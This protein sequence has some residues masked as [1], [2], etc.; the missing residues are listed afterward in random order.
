[1]LFGSGIVVKHIQ[2][3]ESLLV[4][5]NIM[6]DHGPFDYSAIGL[7]IKDLPNVVQNT[8][9]F[10]FAD[11]TM[12]YDSMFCETTVLIHVIYMI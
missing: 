6:F 12:M 9:C 1:M 4:S 7:C 11:Y 5:L 2:Q 3:H 10:M 8:K